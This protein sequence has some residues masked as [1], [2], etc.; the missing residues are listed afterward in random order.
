[1]KRLIR[2]AGFNL[3]LLVLLALPVILVLIWVEGALWHH[4]TYS[5]GPSSPGSLLGA[6]IFLWMVELPLTIVGGLAHQAVLY[7]IP[8][9][10]GSQHRRIAI[11]VSTPIVMVVPL[12]FGYYP[13]VLLRLG[14]LIPVLTGLLC[15]GASARPLSRV[16]M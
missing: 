14:V 13:G 7:A 3:A 10:W 8:Q 16:T 9:K 15:Y 12:L 11:L 5:G 2:D 6:F 4:A 1:M